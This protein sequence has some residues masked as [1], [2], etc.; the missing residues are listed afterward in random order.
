[1][2]AQ[3]ICNQWVGGSSPSG[4]TRERL[5]MDKELEPCADGEYCPYCMEYLD[6]E[7][8]HRRTCRIETRI[9]DGIEED[10]CTACGN[11]VACYYRPHY[12]PNCGAKVVDE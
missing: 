12:C 7:Y 4:G 2:V 1:M 6:G 3:L 9:I 8:G 10:F 5:G 11:E